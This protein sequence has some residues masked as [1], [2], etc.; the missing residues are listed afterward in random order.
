MRGFT[1]LILLGHASVLVSPNPSPEP[2][3]EFSQQTEGWVAGEPL[4]LIE[5]FVTMMAATHLIH[6]TGPQEKMR[7]GIVGAGRMGQTLARLLIRAGHYVKLANSR[8][9]ESLAQV[10][11]DLGTGATAGTTEEV[12]RFG[13]VVIIATRWD[14]IQPAVSAL[15]L[16][17]KVV[18]DT[19][20]NRIGPGPEGLIDLGGRTSSEVVAEFV[21]GAHLVKAFNHQPIS[22]L[23]G[24]PFASSAERK[25][26]FIAGDNTDAKKLVSALIRDMGAE[27]IDVGNLQES[28]RLLGAGGPLT[29]H[30]RLLNVSEARKLLD[31]VQ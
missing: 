29:G 31:K 5:V 24:V 20:N 28:G 11:S 18:I 26:L 15:R 21:P 6:G 19:T 4:N 8:G 2:V 1:E 27:P 14:Q 12:A 30:G 10:I 9:P 22:A 16:E 3:A 23:D 7:I 25:A 17:G 13:D